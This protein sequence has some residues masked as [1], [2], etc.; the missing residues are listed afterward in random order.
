V[1]GPMEQDNPFADPQR[2]FSFSLT[3]VPDR[4]RFLKGAGTAVALQ[5][6]A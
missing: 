4:V 1:A 6:E 3:C 2:R 5:K